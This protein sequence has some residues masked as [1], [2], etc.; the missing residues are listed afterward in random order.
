MS[1][2]RA[3]LS[4]LNHTSSLSQSHQI[5]WT[6]ADAANGVGRHFVSFTGI[7][8]LLSTARACVPS[9]EMQ[10]ERRRFNKMLLSPGVASKAVAAGQELPPLTAQIRSTAN[11]FKGQDLLANRTAAASLPETQ[12]QRLSAVYCVFNLRRRCSRTPGAASP[13]AA[14]G[15][16]RRGAEDA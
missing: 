12:S 3:V 7:V 4:V 10:S 1:Q 5:Q 11:E 6:Q 15:S 14:Y 2:S 16:R 8:F 9:R 13:A